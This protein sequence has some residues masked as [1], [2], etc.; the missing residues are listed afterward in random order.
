MTTGAGLGTWGAAAEEHA[1]LPPQDHPADGVR[2]GQVGQFA[3]MTDSSPQAH[4]CHMRVQLSV[5]LTE[6]YCA[7]AGKSSNVTVLP[8]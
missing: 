3:H 7:A 2:P 8:L 5:Q 6:R 4:R 1:A